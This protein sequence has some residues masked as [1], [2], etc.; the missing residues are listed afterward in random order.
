MKAD[1][2]LRFDKP[3][4]ALEALQVGQVV[5][6]GI[7][8]TTPQGLLRVVLRVTP[9]DSGAL[10]VRTAAAPLQVAFKRLHARIADVTDPFKDGSSFL[11]TD[12]RPLGR[13][14]QFST[15]GTLGDQQNY[16]IVV[17]DGDGNIDTTNDQVRIKTTLGGGFAYN[18]SIDVDWGAVDALP[19]VLT[20]C[21]TS[22]A[23]LL[24]G[25]P[26]TCKIDDLMPE[27]KLGLKVDPH[28]EASVTLSGA[29]T[30]GYSKDFDI[31]TILLPPFPVGPLVFQP[32][33]DIIATI[34][35]SASARFRRWHTRAS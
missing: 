10:T 27:L 24:E 34:E 1:G 29:A 33:A 12:T 19:D 2:T 31:G 7:S 14:P 32:T 30:T 13:R 16:D 20:D 26:P 17:F 22:A 28:L 8:P 15:G 11:P 5:L 4:A 25:K 9:E 6:A 18:L 23:N 21:L 35:G 3:T